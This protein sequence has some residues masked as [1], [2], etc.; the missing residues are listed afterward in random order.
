MF[1][2]VKKIKK[3]STDM[4]SLLNILYISDLCYD[5]RTKTTKACRGSKEDGN[6]APATGY[7]GCVEGYKLNDINNACVK[8]PYINSFNLVRMS[9][10]FD[11]RN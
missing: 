4:T 6:C 5:D 11:F 2:F 7:C 8:G 3:I 1:L 9:F 10:S